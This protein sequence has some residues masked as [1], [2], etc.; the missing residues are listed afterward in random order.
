[1]IWF[2]IC[3]KDWN[4]DSAFKIIIP[5]NIFMLQKNL[6]RIFFLS[7]SLS[8]WDLIVLIQVLRN[9]SG[10]RFKLQTTLFIFIWAALNFLF[11]IKMHIIILIL[12]VVFESNNLT[13][14]FISNFQ[15]SN[16]NSPLSCSYPSNFNFWWVK[17][18]TEIERVEKSIVFQIMNKIDGENDET[19]IEQ[20]W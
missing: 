10:A 8:C 18:K 4:F 17:F 1:M 20:F 9:H 14:N 11:F 19:I 16:F 2:D 7:N 15:L 6:K 3:F 12:T 13:F 5:W